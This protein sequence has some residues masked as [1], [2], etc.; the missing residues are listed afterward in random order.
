MIKND[1]KHLLMHIN[2]AENK[3]VDFVSIKRKDTSFS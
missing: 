1:L 3:S 2:K